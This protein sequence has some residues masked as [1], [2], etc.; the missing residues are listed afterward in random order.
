MVDKIVDFLELEIHV[1]SCIE[2]SNQLAQR[3]TGPQDWKSSGYHL[4]KM[5]IFY[6]IESE[7]N[8]NENTKSY[9]ATDN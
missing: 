2:H 9:D 5:V 6:P 4:V 1:C 3:E 8:V 7:R